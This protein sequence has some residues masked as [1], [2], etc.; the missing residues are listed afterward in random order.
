MT[1]HRNALI[2]TILLELSR[3]LASAVAAEPTFVITPYR[4]D[5]VWV[6]DDPARAIAKEPF[7]A[8]VPAMIERLTA[9][10][11]SADRG[12]RLLFS[13]RPFAGYTHTLTLRRTDGQSGWYYSE[14]FHSEGWLCPTLLKY[15][16]TPPARLYLQAQPLD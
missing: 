8:G 11:P 6:F 7:V 5:G 12:F 1:R 2:L 4:V 13:E 14:Q 10:I 16:P 15:F 3:G 9:A